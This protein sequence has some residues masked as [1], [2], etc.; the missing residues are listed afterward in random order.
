MV[1]SKPLGV[2]SLQILLD[3]V[4]QSGSQVVVSRH[5]HY[6][7]MQQDNN[8]NNNTNNNTNNNNNNSTLQWVPV[9]KAVDRNSSMSD[10]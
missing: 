6:Q 2:R 3:F 8:N 10:K 1:I 9:I 4:S 7:L 5:P